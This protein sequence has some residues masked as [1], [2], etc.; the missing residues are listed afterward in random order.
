[1]ERGSGVLG[2]VELGARPFV[3]V[4]GRFLSVDPVEGGNANDYVYPADPVNSFDLDGRACVSQVYP[5]VGLVVGRGVITGPCPQGSNVMSVKDRQRLDKWLT[6][7][8]A[9]AEATGFKLNGSGGKYVPL[10]PSWLTGTL[11]FVGPHGVVLDAREAIWGNR[12]KG[13]ASLIADGW[14]ETVQRVLRLGG[15]AGKSVAS[16]WTGA[17][18]VASAGALAC[19]YPR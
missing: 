10:C 1:V 14:M 12:R 19:R 4:L 8:A 13:A 7:T 9:T 5:Y 15:S 2:V 17:G 18:W 3:P 16:G 6:L 11:D